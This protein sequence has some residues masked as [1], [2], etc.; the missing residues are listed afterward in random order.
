MPIITPTQDD[1]TVNAMAQT[2]DPFS[3]PTKPSQEEELEIDQQLVSQLHEIEVARAKA[4]Y[5]HRQDESILVY[6][7]HSVD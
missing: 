2:T 1:K 6:V 5:Q 3:Q 4:Q 7:Y